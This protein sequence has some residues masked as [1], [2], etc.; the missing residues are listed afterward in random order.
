MEIKIKQVELR[1]LVASEGK[2]LREKNIQY[3]EEGKELP[4]QTFKE[5]Y[6]AINADPE[7]YEEIDEI[8]EN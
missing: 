5:V 1:K 8:S 6:L 7:L 4:R 2:I 3:D